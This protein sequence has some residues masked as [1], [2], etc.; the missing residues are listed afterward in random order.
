L[1]DLENK[2]KQPQ[3]VG[4]EERYSIKCIGSSR[5][6]VN[7]VSSIQWYHADN[8]LFLTSGYDG[9]IYLWDTNQ[10][11]VAYEFKLSKNI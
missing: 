11:E 5:R 9:K 2:K 8:G 10:F 6:H 3:E 1:Y 7:C 4:V